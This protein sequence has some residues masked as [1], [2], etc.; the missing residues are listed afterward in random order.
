MKQINKIGNTIKVIK[1][2]KKNKEHFK[3]IGMT[4]RGWSAAGMIRHSESAT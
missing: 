4:K 1:S 3:G 2:A